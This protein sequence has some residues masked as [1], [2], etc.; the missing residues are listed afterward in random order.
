MRDSELRSYE[1]PTWWKWESEVGHIWPKETRW[2]A[3]MDLTHHVLILQIAG[4]N[5]LY[6]R[7][8][9]RRWWRRGSC[10]AFHWD[11]RPWIEDTAVKWLVVYYL[12]P[13]SA[14][15]A[16][17]TKLSCQDGHMNPTR[18]D[19]SVIVSRN[20]K[21]LVCNYKQFYMFSGKF[22]WSRLKITI[23]WA[24]EIHYFLMYYFFHSQR[25]F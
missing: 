22:C 10:D 7:C 15:C 17:S 21:N 4:V 16:S 12:V 14:L 13:S 5:W 9:H 25:I 11:H 1:S 18:N 2:A 8:L 23:A 20:I 3:E 6:W 19:T 24:R